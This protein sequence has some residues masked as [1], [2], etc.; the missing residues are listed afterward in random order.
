MINNKTFLA[1]IPARGGSK[2]L[3]KKNILDLAGKPLI[4]WS[5]KAAIKSKYIDKVM[6]T[7][8]S[9]EI[10]EMAQKYGAEVPFKRPDYL[11]TD[12]AIR[13]DVIKHTIDF[14]QNENQEKFDY[15]IFLQPTSPLRNETHIDN[16]IE[17][18]F[19]KN[20]DAIVSVCEVEH[21]VQWS[22]L[23]P[24]NKDMSDFLDDLDIKSRSQ[25]LP[26]YHRLNGAIFI[27]DSHKFM[28]SGSMFLKE[29]IFAYVMPQNV[30]ID[31]DTKIDFMFARTMLENK[32]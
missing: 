30:S 10:M 25:D 7:T 13:P 19:E 18:M 21:P 6:V 28:E 3:P 4:S 23:L 22:G 5:I 31:I 8:D 12:M 9:D 1:I 24:D 2:R 26:I 32:S 29:N 17:Y 16:A 20:A 27:C 14:Y 15:I 11:A